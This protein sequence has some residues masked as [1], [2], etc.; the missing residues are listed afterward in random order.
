MAWKA[1]LTG[2]DPSISINH[3]PLMCQWNIIL[4]RKKQP[5]IPRERERVAQRPVQIHYKEI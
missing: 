1:E 5:V 2:K 4:N 3:T